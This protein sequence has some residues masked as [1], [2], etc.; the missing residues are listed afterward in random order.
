M[1]TIQI[2]RKELKQVYNVLLTAPENAYSID[3]EWDQA[4]IAALAVLC[5]HLDLPSGVVR[6]LEDE[7]E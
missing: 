2:T 7:P 1:E 6:P 4:K 5:Y 3:V